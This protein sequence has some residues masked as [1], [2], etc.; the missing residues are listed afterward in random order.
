MQ[1][2]IDQVTVTNW[3]S[4]PLLSLS[5]DKQAKLKQ[6]I[7]YSRQIVVD[8][9]HLLRA[10]ARYR[11]FRS[12]DRDMAADFFAAEDNRVVLEALPKYFGLDMRSRAI[13]T[14]LQTIILK[15]QQIHAGISGPFELVV[16][17]VHDG[18]DIIDGVGDAWKEIK[19]G[20]GHDA[21][22]ALKEIRTSTRGWVRGAGTSNV[23][24]IHLNTNV[25][26]T[27]PAGRVART[28]VH[29]ASHKF[30]NTDDVAYKWQGLKNNARGHAGL[31]NN[32]DSYAWA[33][34]LMWKRRR[35]LASG[36]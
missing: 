11:A 12:V 19:K 8:S 9:L 27:D 7:E 29:E 4:N 36:I 6:S 28:I 32:A 18:D 2:T 3:S 15:Y 10:Y 34:R 13:H 23:G 20:H 21:F 31:I 25:L 14:D 26:R 1:I 17:D 35:G 16:G 5:S 24:R 22:K 30:A 33:G